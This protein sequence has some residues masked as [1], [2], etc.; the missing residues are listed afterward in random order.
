M[1]KLA[2]KRVFFVANVMLYLPLFEQKRKRWSRN[3]RC[4]P[5]DLRRSP[6]ACV[7]PSRSAWPVPPTWPV[8]SSRGSPSG[9]GTYK[10]SSRYIGSMITGGFLVLF[11]PFRCPFLVLWEKNFELDWDAHC[12]KYENTLFFISA[13]H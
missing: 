9:R 13:N 5:S 1:Y 3:G 8:S 11:L 2:I 4:H 6:T 10:H 7:R 12:K